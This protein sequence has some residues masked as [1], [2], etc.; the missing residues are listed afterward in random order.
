MRPT[1]KAVVLLMVHIK[2]HVFFRRTNPGLQIWLSCA[3]SKDWNVFGMLLR[4]DSQLGISGHLSKESGGSEGQSHP[5]L[6]L[7]ML[8]CASRRDSIS[9]FSC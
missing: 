1:E 7:K 9:C 3:I 6:G 5:G 8:V 4:K 2:Q